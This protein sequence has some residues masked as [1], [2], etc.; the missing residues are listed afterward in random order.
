M[1]RKIV[2]ILLVSSGC[3][4]LVAGCGRALG[5]VAGTYSRSNLTIEI[6]E[7]LANTQVQGFTSALVACDADEQLIGG[8][9]RTVAPSGEPIRITGSY[10]ADD[11]GQ[12][13][14][15][16]ASPTAWTVVGYSP[17]GGGKLVAYALCLKSAIA[18][19][20]TT[21][22]QSMTL[23][24]GDYQVLMADCQ[25]DFQLGGGFVTHPLSAGTSTPPLVSALGPGPGGL[26][27]W[28]TV[29]QLPASS[30]S[31]YT[32]ESVAVCIS[33]MP[34]FTVTGEANSSHTYGSS[35]QTAE[36]PC[37]S[38]FALAGGG[39]SSD[40]EAN[41]QVPAVTGDFPEVTS[42]FP[43]MDSNNIA[44][45]HVEAQSLTGTPFTLTAWSVCAAQVYFNY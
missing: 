33:G 39:F 32:A 43:V 24:P 8:G 41:G 2:G 35:P 45:W 21:R 30:R 17:T 10:P 22:V 6:Y 11:T 9:F 38:A 15:S 18:V 44:A 42:D 4:L 20:V 28:T 12:E 34:H 7:G 29:V 40:L 1:T 26:M 16:G 31:S 13:V 36:D 14:P 27:P 3:L 25:P 5:I 23:K 37:P 19:H